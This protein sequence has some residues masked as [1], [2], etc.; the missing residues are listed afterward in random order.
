MKEYKA[1][2]PL[3]HQSSAFQTL[4][5]AGGITNCPDWQAEFVD[6]LEDTNLWIYN[7]RRDHFDVNDPSVSTEQIEWEHE[8]LVKAEIVSFWFCKETLCPIT[9][10]ELGA[11]LQ[12]YPS[13]R[14]IIGIEPGYAR[15][16]DVREQTRLVQGYG[17]KIPIYNDLND[18]ANYLRGFNDA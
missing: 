3:L 15:E 8:R 5:L 13:P 7:P 6:K 4:F 18:M 14:V 2:D 17:P 11:A 1:P 12:N 9:L 16:F 10:F